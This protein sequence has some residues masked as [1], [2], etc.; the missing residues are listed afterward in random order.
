MK[1][2]S[3]VRSKSLAL[4]AFALFS[5]TLAP[6]A[7]AVSADLKIEVT[8]T[9]ANPQ[10]GDIIQYHCVATN[11]GPDAESEAHGGIGP[12]NDSGGDDK[13][14]TVD[15]FD[16][17]PFFTDQT[18]FR[19]FKFKD[20][21]G[22]V[23]AGLAAGQSGT[24]DA[25]YKATADGNAVRRIGVTTDNFNDDPR[26][27][28]NDMLVSVTIG[29]GTPPPAGSI[30]VPGTADPFLAGMPDGS[31]AKGDSAPAQS[32]VLVTGVT[33]SPGQALSF[34]ATGSTDYNG[35]TPTTT[36][37]GSFTY[38]SGAENGIAG[39]IYPVNA[40]VGVF[41]NDNRPDSTAA[42]PDTDFSSDT[43]IN[44]TEY[45]PQLKQIFFI[46]DGR[47]SGGVTQRVIVPPGATRLFL[48]NSD[49]S[50]WYNNSGSFSVTVAVGGGATPPPAPTV[51][52]RGGLSATTLTV[53][54][55][56]SASTVTAGNAL[57]FVVQQA[58]TPANLNVRVQWSTTPGV[59]SS[60]T[61]LLDG[62]G[63]RMTYDPMLQAYVLNSKSYPNQSGLSFRAI[64]S[65]G[66]YA[67]SISNVVGAFDL[68][69]SKLP[70]G[71]TKLRFT[72][73]GPLADMA[74]RASLS[75]TPSG[76]TVRVQSSITPTDESSWTD[77]AN[78]NSGS[79][80]QTIIRDQFLLFVNNYPAAS[81]I[82]FRA[83][84]SAQG[85]ADSISNLIGPKIITNDT[86][87]KV[88]VL[89]Q[90]T[91]G[92]GTKDDPYI[93]E[94][95]T[96]GFVAM[97][98]SSRSIKTVKLK[99]DGQTVS[100]YASTGDPNTRYPAI[101]EGTIGD[102]TFEAMAID[103][104]GAAA[105]DGTDPIFVRI[106]PGQSSSVKAERASGSSPSVAASSG[107]A[108]TASYDGN[109]NSPATWTN[110]ADGSLGVPG[111]S[112]LAIVTSAT[113]TIDSNIGDVEVGALTINGGGIVTPPNGNGALRVDR[114]M[115]II[116]GRIDRIHLQIPSTCQVTMLNDVDFPFFGTVSSTGSWTMHGAGGIAGLYS[117]VNAGN[118]TFVPP[119]RS[120]PAPLVNPA[121]G[122]RVV[123]VQ[124]DFT[125][126]GL[127]TGNMTAII[128]GDGSSL[129]GNDGASLIG[130]DGGSLISGFGAGL[131]TDN[132]S[133]L[134][135]NDG[136][137]LISQDGGSVIRTNTNGATAAELNPHVKA[138]TASAGF[139]QSGGETNLSAV[140][141]VGPV[142]LNGGVLSGTGLIQG[143]LTNNGGYISPGHSA[144]GIAV[145]GNFTQ[146]SNGTT[147]IE[148]AGAQ[149]GQ[150]D[151][152]QVSGTANLGGALDLKLI[153]G[154]K[155]DPADT[156]NPVAY[157]NASG[158]F[159]A[160]SSNAQVSVNGTGIVATVDATA[161]QPGA[162][163]LLNISTRM[164][165][166]TGENVLIGGFIVTGPAGSTK[167]VMIRGLGPSLAQQG[168]P[169]TLS[170]P[171]LEL[172]AGDGSIVTI[173]DDWQQGDTSQIPA[174]FGPS[175]PK[176]SVIIAILSVGSA[177]YSNYTAILKGAQD[178][179]GVGLCEVYDLERDS[180]AQLA[181]I[182][183]R[184]L[185]ES[186]DNVM[187]GG[188]IVGGGDPAKILVRAIGPSLKAQ[189]VNGALN[190]TTL[191]LHDSNG[192]VIS[193]DD[194][195]ET[196]E[197]E[198]NA[199]T[200]P[201]TS[202]RESAIVQTLVPG[203]YTAI[204]RG[205][206]GATGVGLVE[207]YNL[208]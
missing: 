26:L 129:I 204:V 143:D 121:A 107:Q 149:G 38:P 174:G 84:A 78:G 62:N 123:Q 75:A 201:P 150:F 186:G 106:I 99:V 30:T 66:G 179:T 104:L 172:H 154:Y 83:I 23:V 181:N 101:F 25:Y 168:V 190:D 171:L 87:P 2:L 22:N 193:N 127:L 189:G 37:D 160:V 118:F 6:R 125:N 207:A 115:T 159:A 50:G 192:A 185:V 20:A 140:Y 202:D 88:T 32:P 169:N 165:V 117:F 52:P 81:G 199:S 94:P 82:F 111:P 116:S 60:W 47:T 43:K 27:S 109:W 86:P 180:S 153:N 10:I 39:T 13:Y 102:H 1:T 138:A 76:V 110:N 139:N 63:G 71:K 114:T 198:I 55:S 197:A 8:V 33:F 128:S 59:E 188:V 79:M 119:L 108:F 183:T 12:D 103:D 157:K 164:S 120:A 166:Q 53:N 57:R 44:Y 14:M 74:F 29:S 167:K 73:H 92:S 148:A 178:E 175:S 16:P 133:G 15:H 195:R 152:L 146:G 162:A 19:Y 80:S 122:A 46:G 58:G 34:T 136:G 208:Q 61:D 145:V 7:N 90:G 89:A 45:A 21:N 137:S 112:D 141:L 144:G 4:V 72:A 51:P 130:N 41:L 85:Y 69:A 68:S 196:Q 91:S 48:A 161:P 182:S 56:S 124:T 96:S 77:L 155:P 147:I 142:T 173:N 18:Y 132:G 177:G 67:D 35:S 9:P 11:L 158:S 54:G 100:E 131:V 206:N 65:A 187:I 28:N 194:W 170:D 98:Q 70:L 42:P 126:T 200:V 191:E 5:A 36:P 93:V 184:G 176:E 135:S 17:A 49:G 113:V 156:F 163:K 64:S 24:F 97:V 3:L 31:A 105:R 95:D 151:S 205:K 134:I 203:N 40:L